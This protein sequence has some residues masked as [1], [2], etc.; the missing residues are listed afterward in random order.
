MQRKIMRVAK[1]EISEAKLLA[2]ENSLDQQ[3]WK[4]ETYESQEDSEVLFLRAFDWS[5]C[6]VADGKV[7]NDMS[8][9]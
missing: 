8:Q 9:R 2:L 4:L 6:G 5:V 7:E 1:S 3:N